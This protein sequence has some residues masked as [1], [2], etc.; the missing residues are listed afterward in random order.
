M[1]KVVAPQLR[2]SRTSGTGRASGGGRIRPLRYPQ[3]PDQRRRTRWVS[4]ICAVVSNNCGVDGWGLG[5]LLGDRRLA[6]TTSSYVGENKEFERQFLSGELEVELVP[7]GTL[8][9]RLRAGGAGIPAFF[10]AGRRRHPGR[11]RWHCPGATRPTARSRWR[12]PPRRPGVRRPRVRPG[13]GDHRPTSPSCTPGRATGTATWCSTRAPRNFNP[14]ARWRA[15]SR[16]PRSRS[17]SSRASS[18]RTTVHTPGVFVQRVVRGPGDRAREAHRATDRPHRRRDLMTD[19]ADA[20][21]SWRRARPASSTDGAVRQ[22]RH[23]PADPRSRTISPRRSVVLQS[24]NGILGVG[25][26]PTEEDGR[27]RSDQ[28]RQGDRDGPPGR[29]VLRLGDLVRDDPRRPHRCSRCSGAM[30]VSARGDLANWMIPGKMVKGMGGA[31]DLV[32]GAQARHRD[33][34]ARRQGR[35]AQDRRRSARCRS[36]GRRS[37]TGSSPTSPSSTSPLGL[38]LREVVEGVSPADVQAATGPPLLIP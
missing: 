21:R 28:R 26:Y 38:V 32:H 2:R 9:E 13:G 20:R 16:S 35:H 7:Q 17:S 37:S 6:R 25:P 11:R 15:D 36:P 5:V 1:D 8:A 23:R 18:T 10:T 3:R 31:M 22:P 24:E 33:D 30:Q 4:R 34:G 19:A 29:V 27:P 12:S 14:L